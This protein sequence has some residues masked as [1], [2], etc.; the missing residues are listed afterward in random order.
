VI[1]TLERRYDPSSAGWTWA[2]TKLS[3]DDL[4]Q[5]T[6]WDLAWGTGALGR[7]QQLTRLYIATA[8]GGFW[9]AGVSLE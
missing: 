5:R 4:E 3:G 9:D 8:G 6:V 1:V 7:G 2:F